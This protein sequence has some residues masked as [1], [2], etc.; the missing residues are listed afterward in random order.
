M[1]T[2]KL[3][4]RSAQAPSV[5]NPFADDELD[6][7]ETAELLTS[8]LR[9]VPTPY[10][11]AI[12][13]SW[14]TGKS[15]LL[16]RWRQQLRS[17]GHPTIYFNAWEVDF[18]GDPLLALIAEVD[19]QLA[20]NQSKESPAHFRKAKAAVAGLMR[21][22]LS[23]VLKSYSGG[24]LDLQAL[25]EDMQSVDDDNLIGSLLNSYNQ[26]KSG[27]EVFRS[28]LQQYIDSLKSD[29][30]PAFFFIDELD[31][32]RPDFA[33]RVLETLKHLFAADG[34]VFVLAVDKSQLASSAKVVY[35]DALRFEGYLRRFVDIDF[36]LPPPNRGSYVGFL[37]N[38]AK[39]SDIVP[40]SGEGETYKSVLSILSEV[41][42]AS[43][44]DIER[45]LTYVE[46]VLR[47]REGEDSHLPAELIAGL[48]MIKSARTDLYNKFSNSPGAWKE[49]R[50]AIQEI[51]A[52][53]RFL[54]SKEG[55][56][57]EGCLESVL[58]DQNS[59]A[60]R[61]NEYDDSIAEISGR[62]EK[63]LAHA[64]LQGMTTAMNYLGR[65]GTSPVATV[66]KKLEL[67]VRF[68]AV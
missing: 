61:L 38:D 31:R 9:S 68:D 13:G 27:F 50:S 8:F 4:R 60:R 66:M 21:R 52:G 28:Y 6:R 32:C 17:D 2:N 51:S 63:H 11:L 47:T 41:F 7:K 44:R 22:S 45:A 19:R 42:S 39:L 25:A 56:R 34:I 35:G 15:F 48:A 49:I 37:W 54:D 55:K 30:T 1:S 57:F 33:L 16:E 46:V 18:A 62:K 20:E 10:V 5:S 43:L 64:Y 67:A 53:A 23:S 40:N 12:D 36:Q 26:E 3:Y 29:A 65:V 14:G 58:H 24:I 59:F